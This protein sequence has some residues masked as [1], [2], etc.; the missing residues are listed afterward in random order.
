[1]K[2]ALRPSR[3]GA[4]CL[5]LVA[6]FGAIVLVGAQTSLPSTPESVIV[7]ITSTTI[8]AVPTP[9]PSAT[10]T[11]TATPTASPTPT[12]P[13]VR[14]SFASSIDGS[15]RF[16]VI[17]S[18]GDIATDR[19]DARNN[20]DGNPEIFLFDYAQRRIFQITDTRSALKSAAGSPI[21]PNN[22]EVRVVNLNPQISHDGRRIVFI[23]NAYVDS[24]PALGPKRFN[25]D[26]VV[27]Q[28]RQD[29]NTEIFIYEVPAVPAVDLSS[30]V[31]VPLTDLT[32]GAMTRVTN[33][34]ATALPAPGT[35]SVPP[36]FA[37]DNDSPMPNDDASLVA[38]SSQVR[39]GIPGAQNADGNREIF[40][41]NR[42]LQTYVQVTNTADRP[43]TNDNPL[44]VLV[45]NENPQL[46]GTG[47]VLAFLSN[48]DIG[49][50]EPE[51]NRGNGELYVAN[52]DGTAV[53]NL[54]RVT[55]TPPETRV[56]VQQVS[57]NIFTQGRRLSRSGQ[58]LAF[59]STAPF[60]ADGSL[61]G[62]LANTYGIYIYNVTANTFAQVGNR[63]PDAQLPDIGF[64]HPT[65]TG[66]S[67]RV[68]FAS[69]LNFRADGTVADAAST[70]GL[71]PNRPTQVWSAPAAMPNQLSRLTR[72]TLAFADTQPLPSDTVRRLAF[73]YRAETGGGNADNSAE[74]HYLLVPAV[75]TE[76]P[77]PS[78]SPAASPAPVQLSTG[79]SDRPVV[80]AS[81]TPSPTPSADAVT[82][83]AP[84]M[85]AIGRSTLTLAPAPAE[86]SRDNASETRRRPAL[87]VELNGV[88][89]GINGSAAGL[90][91]VSPGQINFVVPPGLAAS[92]TPVPVT[93]FNRSTGTLIRTSLQILPAQPD[94]FT[95][96][97]GP[98]GRAAVL[99]VT[100]PCIPPFGEP[101]TVTTPR[102]VGSG[103]TGNC[104]SAQTEQA[105]TELLIM[106]TGIRNLPA[107]AT[108]TV[109]IG[110]TDLTGSAIVS[111]GPSQT[112]GFDQLIVRLPASL[113]GAGD[114]P[115]I[116]SVTSGG[117]TFSSRPADTAPRIRI[118]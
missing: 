29:A 1:M 50:N 80:A 89:V 17:E 86:V 81:P 35:A 7:Q 24:N 9:T 111:F 2:H 23:S 94:I 103:T 55:S 71:N 43:P 114:V 45:F 57:V 34:P 31:E 110:T 49:S 118:Q 117:Q 12:P 95:S 77:A 108:F 112:P 93:I 52:F 78:P 53:G 84:G 4:I 63:V 27:A 72:L 104:S 51:A 113:A 16:V 65:F 107:S 101:F 62:S 28:L 21:D 26:E 18:E 92:T 60:N 42:A 44:G 68:V 40:V 39:S 38:F 11:P 56:G 58:F 105:P 37:R 75:T 66:D 102:P 10:P 79:A 48:A 99:N 91:F 19:S 109:R 115:V 15:G 106:L 90:Y 14:N 116:V 33:T 64:R 83:L 85:L 73:S 22:I 3:V 20:R 88:T 98:G 96:T 61:N 41:F 100:N 25:G 54:R 87:P 69:G 6:L 5:A 36:F 82:G 97:N 30:G 67:T 74:A 59:E 32:A 13:L 47:S 46:S 70:E 76:V 8:P